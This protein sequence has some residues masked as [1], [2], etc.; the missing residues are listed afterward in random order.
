[1]KMKKIV[2]I[3]GGGHAKVVIS[4]LKKTKNYN[5]VGYLDKINKNDILGI[6]YLGNDNLLFELFSSGIKNAVLG[7]GQI[8][9]AK[10]RKDIVSKTKKIGFSF[11]PIISNNAQINEEVSIGNGTVIMDNVVIESGTIIGQ[12]CIVNTSSS[13]NHD[14]FVD[15]FSHLAPRTT[16]SGDVKIGQEVFLGTGTIIINNINIENNV[17]ISA[18]SCV[19]KSILESGVYRGDPL[20]KI[21]NK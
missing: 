17:V 11:P 15:N 7:L 13:I 10:I 12:Y 6:P 4:L 18:G 14:C 20:R 5:I 8:K 9:S 21:K 19:M 1:M 2:V 16:I 3:G